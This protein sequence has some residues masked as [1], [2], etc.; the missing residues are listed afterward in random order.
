[1]RVGDGDRPGAVTLRTFTG[2]ASAPPFFCP[3][4]ALEA[5]VRVRSLVEKWNAAVGRLRRTLRQY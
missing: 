5:S 4:W 3:P 1:M 2:G